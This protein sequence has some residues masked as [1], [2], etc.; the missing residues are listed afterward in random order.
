MKVSG[1]G[2]I[3]ISNSIVDKTIGLEYYDFMYGDGEFEM[4]TTN[5][6]SNSASQIQGM[7]NGTASPMNLYQTTKM[8]YSSDTPLIG[9]KYINSKEFYGGIGA[10]V[11]EFFA[12]TEMEKTQT[13]FFASTDPA[14][15]VTDPTT[16]AQLRNASLAH[17]VG[18]DTKNS[19]NGTWQ[20][21]A[22][23]HKIFYKDIKVHEAF[24][25]EFEIEKMLTFHENPTF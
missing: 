11:Q 14:T 25:G 22:N 18:T 4:Y 12:V 8:T 10:E 9:A 5:E 17:I 24:S 20:T 2:I 6:E 3:D 16:M 19:F 1:T 13:T 23:W 21:D 15:H 7:I